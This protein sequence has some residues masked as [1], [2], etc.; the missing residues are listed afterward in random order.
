MRLERDTRVLS[1]YAG[2]VVDLMITPHA[3][4][5]K[6]RP[7]A[8]LKPQE[9]DEPLEAIVFVP[10]GIGKKI[11][12]RDP[13][14]IYPTPSAAMN[15]GTSR[16][17]AVD[18]GDSR[19]RDGDARRAQAQVA[20][21][22]L[23]RAVRRSGPAEHPRQA[24][25]IRE[26]RHCLMEDEASELAGLVVPV[27]FETARLDR[28]ALLSLDRGRTPPP[29]H[30]GISLGQTT[31]RHLLIAALPFQ[32][33][34]ILASWSNV[35]SLGERSCGMAKQ[36]PARFRRVKTPTVLQME[37]TE[38]G[39]AA[40]GIILAYHG[41]YVPLEELRVE[42]RVSRDGS[43]ALYVKKTAEK[44]GLRPSMT[45][46]EA[47]RGL[48]PPF[49]VFWELNHFLVVE[50]FAARRRLPERPGDGPPSVDE[51]GLRRVLHR[52]RLHVRARAR[53]QPRRASAEH[54]GGRSSANAELRPARAST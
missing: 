45:F 26:D 44:Y 30:A 13:V 28:D 47:L 36:K 25:E 3:L 49:V 29:D 23:P 54:L 4:V 31:C 33:H 5:E 22:K 43:N 48:T 39:A 50:G 18:L 1:P 34:D 42:C 40:L 2:K 51:R 38:C 35:R 8:L 46:D 37:A 6:G 14:E 12:P 16:G 24:Q 10:A 27:R 11:A 20:R 53:L 15:T 32:I 9:H 41:R 52:D 19:H 21:R 17:G 7:G